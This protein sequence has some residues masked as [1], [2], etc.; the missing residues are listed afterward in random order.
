MVDVI[1]KRIDKSEY[2][3]SKL[4]IFDFLGVESFAIITQRVLDYI[5]TENIKVGDRLFV[6]KSFSNSG[7]SVFL[8]KK[9]ISRGA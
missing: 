8:V 1:I 4:A 6:I 7:G 3:N 2:N 5:D 9:F